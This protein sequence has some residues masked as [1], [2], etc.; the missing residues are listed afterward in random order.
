VNEIDLK[1]ETLLNEQAHDASSEINHEINQSRLQLIDAIRQCEKHNLDCLELSESGHV[2]EN[3]E[4]IFNKFCFLVQNETRQQQP[5]AAFTDPV[6]QQ[7]ILDCHLIVTDKYISSLNLKYFKEL[8]KYEGPAKNRHELKQLDER[9]NFF[10]DLKHPY[11]YNSVCCMDIEFTTRLSRNELVITVKYEDLFKLNRVRLINFYIDS[12]R[13]DALFLFKDIRNL[14]LWYSR[15]KIEDLLHLVGLFRANCCATTSITTKPRVS[16]LLSNSEIKR[17]DFRQIKMLNINVLK[18]NSRVYL[19]ENFSK[20]M[21]LSDVGLDEFVSLDEL[22]LCASQFEFNEP[23]QFLNLTNLVRLSLHGHRCF[24]SIVDGLFNGLA[25]LE[26]LDLNS[27]E[28]SCIETNAF[29]PLVKL[30]CLILISNKLESLSGGRFVGLGSLKRLKLNN[31]CISEIG[32]DAFLGLGELEDL[33][34][35][36]NKLRSVEPYAFDHLTLLKCL[37]LKEN[38]VVAV[39]NEVLIKLPVL[40]TLYSNTEDA[41]FVRV[42]GLVPK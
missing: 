15:F 35:S 9:N 16:I 7:N 11:E 21:K 20:S 8:L 19:I 30:K 29:A 6:S 39:W 10:F 28:I 23:S 25:C 17:A 41:A 27:N 32:Q 18:L 38:D 22:D 26:Y 42:Q 24:K 4:L 34:L 37:N 5:T 36:G 12:I 2:E 1:A 3:N 13:P 40:Q 33:D 14:E 31:N